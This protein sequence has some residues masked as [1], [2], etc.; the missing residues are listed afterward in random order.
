VAVAIGHLAGVAATT[1]H[2]EHPP[3][4]VFAVLSDPWR[5]ADWVVGAKCIRAVD[6][7]WPEPGSR[8]HHR[9][10]AGPFTIDDSTVLEAYEPDRRMVLRARARPT[11]VARV[12]LDLVPA[13]GGTEIHMEEHPVSGFA[14]RVDNPLLDALVVARNR[15]SLRRL[16]DLVAEHVRT[17]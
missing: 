10:G 2:V 12:T 17:G 4:A 5:F 8:F 16:A 7:N 1:L 11:G 6:A 15:R 14:K 13:G 9:F 3:S